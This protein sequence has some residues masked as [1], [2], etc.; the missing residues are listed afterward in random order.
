LSPLFT[1]EGNHRKDL[2]LTLEI[3]NNS[4]EKLLS[5]DSR[6]GALRAPR[7]FAPLLGYSFAARTA[8]EL[9]TYAQPYLLPDDRD[10]LDVARNRPTLSNN[11]LP[12]GSTQAGWASP[13]RSEDTAGNGRRSG[14][15]HPTNR[16][17]P[18]THTRAALHAPKRLRCFASGFPGSSPCPTFQPV[19]PKWPLGGITTEERNINRLRLQVTLLANMRD[20]TE[21][22]P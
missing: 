14:A 13:H 22:L 16:N 19:R 1:E 4:P 3:P 18:G 2:Q 10:T 15:S 21:L 5:I 9:R 12:N 11:L 17:W 7:G 20:R 6:P 8:N